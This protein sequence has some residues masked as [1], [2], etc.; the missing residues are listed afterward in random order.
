MDILVKI[1]TLKYQLFGRAAPFQEVS[2]KRNIIEDGSTTTLPCIDSAIPSEP[3]ATKT[4]LSMEGLE[5]LSSVS[6]GQ[7]KGKWS[8]ED[9]EGKDGGP[10]NSPWSNRKQ[11]TKGWGKTSSANWGQSNGDSAPPDSILRKRKT[12]E[13]T[14]RR[15]SFAQLL[16]KTNTN[17]S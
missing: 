2:E 17:W 11:S 14:S 7:S 10:P 13:E 4:K 9:L 6:C 15:T 3:I 1:P 12:S 5:G 8:T 16:G